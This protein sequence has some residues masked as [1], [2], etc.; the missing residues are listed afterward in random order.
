M[1][2]SPIKTKDLNIYEGMTIVEIRD[3]IAALAFK[4]NLAATAD[5]VELSNESIGQEALDEYYKEY[6]DQIDPI[7]INGVQ[8]EK[9]KWVLD[10][11]KRMEAEA[12]EGEESEDDIFGAKRLDAAQHLDLLV[13]HKIGVPRTSNTHWWLHRDQG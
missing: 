10:M 3:R 1:R 7:T 6:A 2:K 13:T 12:A 4:K 5:K 11:L 9:A 8:V